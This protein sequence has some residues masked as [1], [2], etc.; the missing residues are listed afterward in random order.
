M[1]KALLICLVQKALLICVCVYVRVCMCVCVCE[2]VCV[3]YRVSFYICRIIHVLHMHVT[4]SK[5]RYVIEC[6]EV[7]FLGFF[8]FM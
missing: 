3:L 5:L 4:E 1:Q 7:S 8:A 6:R 2:C